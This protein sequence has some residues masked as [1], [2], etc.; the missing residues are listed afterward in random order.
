MNNTEIIFFLAIFII[1]ASCGSLD[2]KSYTNYRGDTKPSGPGCYAKCLISD[3]YTTNTKEILKYTGNNF[4]NSW[5][6][7]ILIQTEPAS[8][9]WV[10]KKAD[11]RCVSS[12]P[13]DCL[14]WCLI[15]KEAKYDSHYIVT[16]T[17][18]V[19]EFKVLKVEEKYLLEKG[20]FTQWKEIVCAKDQTFEFYEQVQYA[21]IK[22]NYNLQKSK[23]GQFDKVTKKA[24]TKF[25]KDN[26]L[27][28]GN[29][30]LET[31]ELLGIEY[32]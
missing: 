21:L 15:E 10:K 32:L 23:P 7:E 26:N 4:E 11:P 29:F 2:N 24:L 22:K 20:G 30:D 13:D 27:P 31:I 19:K 17:S 5:V 12:N 14:V 6:E 3:S 1:F 16:D 8:S 9:A 28:V 18:Q 25:Q